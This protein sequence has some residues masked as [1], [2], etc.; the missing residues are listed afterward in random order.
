MKKM[1]HG[2]IP[3][4]RGWRKIG[5]VMKLTTIIYF[6]CLMQVSATVYS[7]ATKFTF[8]M[9]N[10]QV[11]D[12]LRKIE[13]N[14][15]FRFF[16]QNEQVNVNRRVTIKV[17]N[18]TVEQ[19]LDEIFAGEGIGYKVMHDFLILLSPKEMLQRE[20]AEMNSAYSLQQKSV[21]G[22]V[23]DAE[24]QPLPGVSIV[25]KGTTQGTVTN[26]D[27]EYSLSN[28]P[29]DATLQFSFVGM[30][31]QEVKVGSKSNIN[32]ILKTETIGIEE[33]V[34]IGYGTVKKS[35]LTGSVA[36]IDGDDFKVQ[37][38]T[39]ISE[40]FTGNV[41]G[42]YSIQNS[43]A[44]GGSSDIEIRGKNSISA[45]TDPL[46]VVDGAIFNGSMQ[47]I[48]PM[49]VKNI[50]VL[51]DA[52]S[53]A[54]YGAKAASGVIIITTTKGT[55]GSPKISFSAK[56]GLS[57][58]ANNKMKAY[59]VDGYSKFRGDWLTETNPTSP[60]YYYSN[61]NNLPSNLSQE[62]WLNYSNNPNSD[63]ILE[64][65]GRLTFTQT[66]IDN[67][68]EG[69]SVNWFDEVMQSGLRQSYD[70]NV[71]GGSE[72]ISYY[73]SFGHVD[74]EGI[75]IGDKFAANRSRLNVSALIADFLT[76]GTN[77]Q[78]AHRDN[79]G[80]MANVSKIFTNSPLGSMYND[81]GNLRW[82]PN[83][84]SNGT[85]PLLNTYYQDKNNN[86]CSLFSSIYADLVLPLGFTFKLT[87]QPHFEFERD[88]NYW[89]TNTLNG[90][91]SHTNGY[92]ERTDIQKFEWMVDNL[93]KW[94]RK[95]GIHNFDFTLLYNVEKYQGWSS[96][97]SGEDINP[98]ENLSYH[99]LHSGSKLSIIDN[100]RYSTGDAFMSRINYTLL[101]KYLITGSIRRDGYSAFGLK[102]KRAVFP[103]TALAWQTSREDFWNDNWL[104]NRLK[105]R[106]SWGKNGNR[107][108]GLYSALARLSQEYYY[109]GSQLEIGVYNSSLAND[110]L[111][112]E[113]TTAYNFGFD[114]G[115]F[116][117]RIDISAEFYKSKTEDLL[118]L[119]QLPSI[120]G[121]DDIM[122]NL[123]ELSNMGMDVTINTINVNHDKFKWKTNFVISINRNEIKKLY[124]DVGEYTLMGESYYGELPDFENEWFPGQALDV[125]WDYNIEGVWQ[126]EEA[127]QAAEINQQPG[128]YKVSEV[129]EDNVYTETDDK[130]F[131]G[132]SSPRYRFGMR[133]DIEFLN[134][135]SFS[136]FLRAD[137]GHI[138][139]ISLYSRMSSAIDRIPTRDIPYWTP[140][141]PSDKYSRIDATT[142]IF[143][144]DNRKNLGVYFPLSFLRVQN[145]S[146]SYNI[147][148]N[149]IERIKLNNMR[150]YGSI[151]NLI[152]FNKWEDWD[153][154]SKNM[155][156]PRTFSIGIDLS[157]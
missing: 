113:K 51:K 15:K 1:E 100:D 65:L 94:N 89:P 74:N 18:A 132:W 98:N 48:N 122:S 53:A 42:L 118:V 58:V 6:I 67:Y 33:V 85:N 60:D 106:L 52:S 147:S 143:E 104:I 157:F 31:T 79:S 25:I 47:D 16:Y 134:N 131:L 40:M 92:G 62:E 146:L 155:P 27:G 44:S 81:D 152:C 70:V 43:R 55:K 130:Q 59:T 39:Q 24:G 28:I 13:D 154:E 32:I 140:E 41:A 114:M 38:I 124:G 54:I 145:I 46:I 50:D 76:I 90:G 30:K 23:T 71:S 123:G 26:T 127:E 108:I 72:K 34:A 133:N 17:N 111:A 121:Y 64:W 8:S 80:V 87:Y 95:I 107:D 116:D 57:E 126:L 103:A 29:D 5:L 88:Y 45:G 78:F 91:V 84:H 7:Q 110:E 56:L 77:T 151:R 128:D 49:D 66:E 141:N 82:Y 135:F 73:W 86:S 149:F 119:R 20:M 112:W 21:S 99:A 4:R 150:V 156:I 11:V 61:P 69:N 3:V 136:M 117:N 115:L 153:P 37:Q 120:T 19:I 129:I 75:V 96:Y 10:E 137:L 142:S 139:Y 83:E 14:S 63:P 2:R 36:R 144:G 138:D 97:Q 101:D 125:V 102:N 12:V 109:D 105:I 93:L 68:L 9:K 35:D 22:K 148:N